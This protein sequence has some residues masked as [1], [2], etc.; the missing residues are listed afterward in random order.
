MSVKGD[1]IELIE[2]SPRF[3]MSRELG[4]GNRGVART[5][6][7]FAAIGANCLGCNCSW[8][9][10]HGQFRETPGYVT[11]TCPSCGNEEPFKGVDVK[12]LVDR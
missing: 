9:A 10:R 12:T 6:V 2:A 3:E 11:L 5:I 4:T 8:T 1:K 7:G